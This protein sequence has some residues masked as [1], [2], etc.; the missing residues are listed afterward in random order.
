MKEAITIYPTVVKLEVEP[1]T[2]EV[3]EQW[4]EKS[5]LTN[6]GYMRHTWRK[7]QIPELSVS[8]QLT[9]ENNIFVTGGMY[10]DDCEKTWTAITAH[11]LL[12]T[13]QTDSRHFKFPKQVILIYKPYT[14]RG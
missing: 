4:I 11:D 12:Y 6:G 9:C 3:R 5:C 14:E 13:P 2:H 7:L 1:K 10:I 8:A